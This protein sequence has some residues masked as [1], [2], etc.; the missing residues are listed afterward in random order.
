MAQ[1]HLAHGIFN[2]AF[3]PTKSGEDPNRAYDFS[4]LTDKWQ[5]SNCGI[6]SSINR[7]IVYFQSFKIFIRKADGEDS[8]AP[9]DVMTS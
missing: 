4:C 6:V 9:I 3:I 1:R 2:N 5:F 7:V 8:T